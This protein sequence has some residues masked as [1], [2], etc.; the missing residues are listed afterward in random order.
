MIIISIVILAAQYYHHYRDYH[1]IYC[2]KSFYPMFTILVLAILPLL[3]KYRD[4][5]S[6]DNY[7]HD[8][9]CEA[10]TNIQFVIL[11]FE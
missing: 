10:A 8:I 3:A 11:V 5:I 1:K 9:S 4:N 6:S 7:S 2:S